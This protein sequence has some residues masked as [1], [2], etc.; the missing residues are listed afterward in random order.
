MKK[1]LWMLAACVALPAGADTLDVFDEVYVFGDSLSDGGNIAAT[2]GAD[3]P[4]AVY[5]NGQFTNGNAWTTKLGLTPS[6]LGGTNYAFGGARAADNGDATPDLLTQIGMF[7]AGVAQLSANPLAVIWAGGNDFRDLEP[8]D[9]PGAFVFSIIKTIGK[10]VRELHEKGIRNVVV[11]TLPDFGALPEYADDPLGAGQASFLSVLVN[12]AIRPKTDILNNRLADAD[13]SSF[14]IDG[15]FS[16]VLA[17][18]PEA[19]R[20]LRCLDNIVDC[21]ANPTDYVFYDDIHPMSWVHTTLAQ[22]FEE[23]VLQPVPLPAGA[24]LL[25]T[26][27]AGF[28][29][30]GRRRKSLA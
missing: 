21:T 7:T 14:D 4:T 19:T 11:F 13:I 25:L 12:D 26:G 6:L 9:D 18:V 2:L 16:E 29:V 3:F 22:R 15:L 23:S 20:Q 8:T 28:G 10:G 5:P 30:W 27:L 24:A 17:S 1:T